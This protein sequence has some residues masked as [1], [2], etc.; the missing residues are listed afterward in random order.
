MHLYTDS[1][2]ALK[3]A[4]M[5]PSQRL[6]PAE[7]IEGSESAANNGVDVP[8]ESREKAVLCLGGRAGRRETPCENLRET[9]HSVVIRL[10]AESVLPAGQRGTDQEVKVP[11][12]AIRRE[13]Q[14][15]TR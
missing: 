9:P 8:V 15:L 5:R 2:A 14:E 10:E 11:K 1:K 4:V 12:H 3:E 7:L 6:S 13:D